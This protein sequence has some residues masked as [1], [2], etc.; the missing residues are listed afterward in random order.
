MRNRKD[1]TEYYAVL[2]RQD[3]NVANRYSLQSPDPK[4]SRP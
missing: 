2:Y 1:G 4:G 3:G